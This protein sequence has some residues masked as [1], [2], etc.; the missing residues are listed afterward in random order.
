MYESVTVIPG[1]IVLV[2]KLTT[3]PLAKGNPVLNEAPKLLTTFTGFRHCIR[4]NPVHT[5]YFLKT[6]QVLA[7]PSK[8]RHTKWTLP[9]SFAN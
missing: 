7:L 3:A 5:I 4:M 6:H 9:F 8:L 1:S 2:E